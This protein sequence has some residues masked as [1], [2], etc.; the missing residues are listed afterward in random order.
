MRNVCWF[1][2]TLLSLK[3]YWLRGVWG[4]LLCFQLAKHCLDGDRGDL[5]W[6][7][8]EALL[9]FPLF[10]S[11]FDM[12]IPQTGSCRM[13]NLFKS[14]LRLI[15]N[16]SSSSYGCRGQEHIYATLACSSSCVY[17][18]DDKWER[19]HISS[20]RTSRSFLLSNGF[21]FVPS[22]P[23]IRPRTESIVF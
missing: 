10:L 18:G 3:T 12:E 19:T 17:C 6:I 16:A 15:D 8:T 7:K 13:W 2:N 14:P 21:T 1:I 11:S 9:P 23:S 20:Q 5:N 22:S 4:H